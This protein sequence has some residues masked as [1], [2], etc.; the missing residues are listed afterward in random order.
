MTYL[1]LP[2]SLLEK[3]VFEFI[4]RLLVILILLPLLYWITFHLQ[5]Y[6]FTIFAT[7]YFEPVS[8]QYLIRVHNVSELDNLFWE[9]LVAI[10]SAL[11]GFVVALTGAAAFAKQPLVKT[12]FSLAVIVI[13]YLGYSYLV[14][15]RL[16]VGNYNPPESM[17]LI[18]LS[19]AGAL[20]F[21]NAAL[22]VAIMTM[23][24]VAFRKLKEREV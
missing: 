17:W 24:Y 2:A 3:F 20:R 18:P 23:S 22:A 21:F 10:E 16:G 9:S 13:F 19:E 4:S 12:L 8:I 6:L 14:V 1:M 7:R 11:L 5:G 15:E